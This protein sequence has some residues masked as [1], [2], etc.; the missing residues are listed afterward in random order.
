MFFARESMNP[1][2][3]SRQ[4]FLR[5]LLDELPPDER[6]E[7]DEALIVDQEYFD[8]FQEARHDLIDAYVAGELLADVRLRVEKAIFSSKNGQQA[9]SM[10]R[11]LQKEKAVAESTDTTPLAVSDSR[12]ARAPTPKRT[13]RIAFLVSTLAACILL[14]VAMI[15][16]RQ[17]AIRQNAHAPSR[18]SP[19]TTGSAASEKRGAAPLPIPPRTSTSRIHSAPRENSV[20]ALAMPM[21][22]ARGAAA[23]PIHLRPDVKQIEIQWPI[24]SD[25][26]ASAYT[27]EIASDQSSIVVLPQHGPLVSIDDL[28]VANFFLA[29]DMLQN[30]QYIL[31]L[32]A[33]DASGDTPVAASSVRISR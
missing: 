21:G 32:R 33:A 28:R 18:P 14:V 10:A 27:L 12:H 15:H 17:T 31:R 4:L 3:D 5:Y 8:S 24:P 29:V 20:L 30:G 11:A 25:S 19:T 2:S 13:F 6:A 23:L 22:T 26:T 9:L 1:P 7:V 16:V